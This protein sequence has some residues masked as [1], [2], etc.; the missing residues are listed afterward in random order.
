MSACIP[1]FTFGSTTDTTCSP[2]KIE[3][4][5]WLVCDVLDYLF[6]MPD[7]LASWK[8]VENPTL[9]L[10]F[11]GDGAR[12]SRGKNTIVMCFNVIDEG[13]QWQ[14]DYYIQC[15]F[16]L[17]IFTVHQGYKCCISDLHFTL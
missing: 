14:T 16:L 5:Y 2:P 15:M 6:T 9:R 11:V 3:G 17:N 13:T 7:F 10:C 1:L 12:T 8:D 4:A